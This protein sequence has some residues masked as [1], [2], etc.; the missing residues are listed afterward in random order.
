MLALRSIYSAVNLDQGTC[1][2]IVM[3]QFY[4]NKVSLG[5][6]ITMYHLVAD[7]IYGSVTF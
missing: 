5:T 7:I 1:T 2:T 3:A 4:A 6:K